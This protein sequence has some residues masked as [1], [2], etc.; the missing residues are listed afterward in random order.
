MR[1]EGII[2]ED[3]ERPTQLKL[4]ENHFQRFAYKMVLGAVSPMM[5]AFIDFGAKLTIGSRSLM[6]LMRKPWVHSLVK[7]GQDQQMPLL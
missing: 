5:G 3:W 2:K 7:A 4:F 1:N 6:L